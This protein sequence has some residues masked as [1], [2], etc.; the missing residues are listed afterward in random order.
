[1]PCRVLTWA[2]SSAL[3]SRPSRRPELVPERLVGGVRLREVG[4]RSL[5]A[6]DVGEFEHLG[7]DG[8]VD[9]RP[10]RTARRGRRRTR[11]ADSAMAGSAPQVWTRSAFERRST[12]ST[13]KASAGCSVVSM[14]PM[15]SAWS[16][17]VTVPSGPPAGPR[18]PN[19]SRRG[20]LRRDRC[21]RCTTGGRWPCGVAEL[22]RVAVVGAAGDAVDLGLGRDEAAVPDAVVP[23]LE[24]RRASCPAT[25]RSCRRPRPRTRSHRTRSTRRACRSRSCGRRGR[26]GR[27][28]SASK[29]AL[30]ASLPLASTVSFL[31]SS[32]DRLPRPVLALVLG[33]P[34]S[35]GGYGEPG[36]VEEA[37]VVVDERRV[38]AGRAGRS[39]CHR[40]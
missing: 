3:T 32:R 20:R 33:S 35:C 39:A 21:S 26:T 22:E 29:S 1:M 38:D 12:S 4:H 40:R 5:V 37:L 25:E 34:T 9:R 30:V 8:P 31:A 14:M 13:S 36:F 11:R 28:W 23:E 17:E 6:R 24:A 19:P 10:A 27:Y 2:S 15:V 18:C 16:F 7:R